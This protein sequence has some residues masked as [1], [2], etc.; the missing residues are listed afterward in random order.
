[1]KPAGFDMVRN[2]ASL[3]LLAIIGTALLAGVNRFTAARIAEQEMRV[4]R[5]R[6]EQ[7][8]GPEQYNNDLMHDLFSFQNER[9]FPSG[10]TVVAYRARLDGKAVAVVLEIAAINGYNGMIKLMV[11]I[12]ENGTLSGVRITSHK[13]TPGLG[14]AIEADKSDWVLG[15][16]G[17]SLLQPSRDG[18]SVKR[19]GGEFDQFTGATITPRAVVDA[20]RLTLEFYAGHRTFLFETAADP[21]PGGKT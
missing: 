2:A 3:A 20:V 10:Q 6:L 8:I 21:T 13:E 1:M 16:S 11:G 9:Y 14:D 4:M 5:N 18:W 17:K 7:I 15:F 12:K 19:D